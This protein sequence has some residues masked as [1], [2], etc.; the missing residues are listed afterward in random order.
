MRSSERVVRQCQGRFNGTRSWPLP[1]ARWPHSS[2]CGA[3]V[4]NT[5]S[6]AGAPSL[7]RYL[8]EGFLFNA[9]PLCTSGVDLQEKRRTREKTRNALAQW[10]ASKT[11]GKRRSG[12]A[13]GDLLHAPRLTGAWLAGP[14]AVREFLLEIGEKIGGGVGGVDVE[15]DMDGEGTVGHEGSASS[16]F[17][18]GQAWEPGPGAGVIG[19][20]VRS[21]V[22]AGA[23]D[24]SPGAVA[25]HEGACGATR[26]WVRWRGSS[27]CAGR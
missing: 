24:W 22:W 19:G 26:A 14:G 17:G 13:A 4:S 12:R 7:H 21:A 16:R 1:G 25:R 15:V 5:A 10:S 3:S 23:A 18:E 2:S 11:R 6:A 20:L 9:A 27:G 8:A